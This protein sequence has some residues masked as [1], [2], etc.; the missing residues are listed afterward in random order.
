[1]VKRWRFRPTIVRMLA[2]GSLWCADGACPFPLTGFNFCRAQKAFIGWWL[3]RCDRWVTF[4]AE[5]F[6]VVHG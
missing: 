3:Y 5:H 2:D 4:N 1:M 6:E